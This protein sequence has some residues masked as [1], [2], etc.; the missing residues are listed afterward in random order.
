[1]PLN[2]RRARVSKIKS[3]L[4]STSHAARD[5][6]AVG[7]VHAVYSVGNLG[8]ARGASAEA[9]SDRSFSQFWWETSAS[10]A[11]RLLGFAHLVGNVRLKGPRLLGF[12]HLVGNVRAACRRSPR[13]CGSNRRLRAVLMQS[14][15]QQ[16]Q[17]DDLAGRDGRNQQ[18][19]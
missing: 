9:V 18:R 19:E 2:E 5:I 17:G 12:V 11:P 8:A 1:V 4:V 6:D 7:G 3:A 10:K 16:H 15:D 14:C 13:R